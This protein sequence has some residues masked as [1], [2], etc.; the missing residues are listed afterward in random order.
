MSDQPNEPDPFELA[1]QA[2]DKAINAASL[3]LSYVRHI[4]DDDAA[5]LATVSIAHSLLALTIMFRQMF[6]EDY[7][8]AE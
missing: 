1:A 7:A 3:A 8:D 5:N 4:R 2:A 6:G